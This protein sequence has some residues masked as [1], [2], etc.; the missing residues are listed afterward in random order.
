M[1]SVNLNMAVYLRPVLLTCLPNAKC[2]FEHGSVLATCTS[3][4]FT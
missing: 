4:M 3:D 2:Q 1:L